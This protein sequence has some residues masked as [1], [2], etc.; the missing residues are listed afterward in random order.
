MSTKTT[1][2]ST[3]QYNPAS[4]SAF[5]TMTPQMQGVLSGYMTDPFNKNGGNPFYNLSLQK[6]LQANQQM[7]QGAISNLSRNM[8]ASGFS[9]GNMPA[10]MQSQL[11][12][13]G[14]ANSAMNSNTFLNNALNAQQ[15]Q[16]QATN[17]AA[18]YKPLQ[19]GQTQTQQQSG[20]GTW[21]PQT[22]GVAAGI[23]LAPFTGGA[24]LLSIPGS[25]S[26]KGGG[27]GGM[28]MPS[29][30]SSNTGGIDMS[31]GGYGGY[32]GAI[33]YGNG[34]GPGGSAYNPFGGF[35]LGSGH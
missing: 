33:N 18:G 13:Q 3:N 5:N 12:T 20:L 2:Q 31:G 30:G 34:Q 14:R 21:L 24:S 16:M 28:M 15:L 23:G 1:T 9:G 26:G 22:L 29:S 11:A 25:L 32:S 35:G 6:G 8:T 10:F 27:G 19:T 4:Q 7:N 17:M